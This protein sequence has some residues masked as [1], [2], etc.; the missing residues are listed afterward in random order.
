MKKG[1]DAVRIMNP[2]LDANG[3]MRTMITISGKSKTVKL[4][5][6]VAEAFLP[7]LEQKP[8]VNHINNNRADNRVR[9]L[10]WVTF[11]ENLDHMMR[12]GRQTFNNG[13]KN[14]KSI[15]TADIVRQIRSEYKPYVVMMK[16]LAV[17][18]GVKKCT[19]KDILTGRSWASVS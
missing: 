10:E 19:I 12:Q 14:G 9:N 17:K 1:A 8:Q 4:H 13:E 11:R 7:N 16:D 5:R 18:Y 6:I 2:A 15:L 3:Y